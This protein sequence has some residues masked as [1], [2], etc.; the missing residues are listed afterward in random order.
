MLY[1]SDIDKISVRLWITGFDCSPDEITR[2]LGVQP[3]ETRIKGEYRIIG[4]KKLIK[5]L[6]KE[7]AWVLK[8]PLS[9]R[10]NPDRHL[11]YILDT[12]NSNKV[13]FSQF[14]NQYDATITFGIYWD[15]CNP[16]ITLDPALLKELSGLNIEVGLDMYYLPDDLSLETARSRKALSESLQ[17]VQFISSS[18]DKTHNE[19][20]AI[21]QSLTELEKACNTLS[22]ILI[23]DLIG[24]AD[25]DEN[26]WRERFDRITTQLK[27]VKTAINNSD[28]LRK[29]TLMMTKLYKKDDTIY[30]YWEIARFLHFTF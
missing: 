6:N 23:P 7:N 18:N 5:R 4:T 21:T 30:S 9:K 26:D 25:L 1:K 14:F 11:R 8:S 28:Y 2:Q 27:I 24:W 3:T 22:G 19:A 17:H 10:V 29:N 15:Y 13:Q 20:K 16:G 12:I